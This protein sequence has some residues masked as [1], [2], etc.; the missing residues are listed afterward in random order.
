MRTIK[1]VKKRGFGWQCKGVKKT[2]PRVHGLIDD[3]K[4]LLSRER[5]SL[6]PWQ[7]SVESS[8][9]A[10][11]PHPLINPSFTFSCS[12]LN[13]VVSFAEALLAFKPSD[14]GDIVACVSRRFVLRRLYTLFF[15]F[16]GSDADGVPRGQRYPFLHSLYHTLGNLEFQIYYSYL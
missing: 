9:T 11:L 12:F 7:T 15:W 4:S 16:S 6:L 5:A 13:S 10:G 2:S 1:W 14:L 3:T 8:K